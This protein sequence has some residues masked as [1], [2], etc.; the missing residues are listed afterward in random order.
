MVLIYAAV[1]GAVDE[2]IAKRLIRFAGGTPGPVYGGEGKSYLRTRIGGYNNAAIHTP[3]I[4]LVDLNHEVEC[5][6]QLCRSWLPKKSAKLCFRVAVHAAEAWLLADR[7]R[8]AKFLSIPL[9]RVPTDPDCEMQPKQL[10]VNLAARSRK[11]DIREDMAPRPGSGRR[12]GP[13]YTSRLMEFVTGKQS[14]WRPAVAA[15]RSDSLQRCVACLKR[16]ID[17]ESRS[18]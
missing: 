15:K 18:S 9:S 11:R 6:P 16:L 14:P 5:A 4:V 10:V 2:A 1:E 13:A 12:V 8:I 3:W 17:S 7:G